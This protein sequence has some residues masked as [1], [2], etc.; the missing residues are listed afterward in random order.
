MVPPELPAGFL[1]QQLLLQQKSLAESGCVCDGIR[2]A[3][4]MGQLRS[5]TRSACNA[6]LPG[7]IV[8]KVRVG[9]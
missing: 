1:F 6:A 5:K 2:K 3:L 8:L 7:S 9:R 4:F